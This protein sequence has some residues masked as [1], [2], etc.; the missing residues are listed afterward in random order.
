MGKTEYRLINSFVTDTPY[1]GSQ[2][3]VVFLEENDT[4]FN[5]ERWLQGVAHNFNYPA[6]S[7]LVPLIVNEEG[8]ELEY[9]LRWFAE[10]V[11][12]FDTVWAR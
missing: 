4:R 7:F 8:Q 1:S 5:D 10:G 12:P 2:V 6:T 9:N 11:R 3:A